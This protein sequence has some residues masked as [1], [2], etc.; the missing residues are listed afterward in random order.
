METDNSNQQPNSDQS[1]RE[2]KNFLDYDPNQKGTVLILIGIIFVI[3]IVGIGG[4]YLGKRTMNQS[5]IPISQELQTSIKVSSSSVSTATVPN[6][7]YV[8][9]QYDPNESIGGTKIYQ[10]KVLNFLDGI[11]DNNLLG[12][13][14]SPKY[15]FVIKD[16][17]TGNT[18]FQYYDKQSKKWITVEDQQQ[19]IQLQKIIQDASNSVGPT[20]AGTIQTCDVEDGRQIIVYQTIGD[21]QLVTPYFATS[22]SSREQPSFSTISNI[23]GGIFFSCDQPL[24]LTKTNQFYYKC[25]QGEATTGIDYYYKIDLISKTSTIVAKCNFE[26]GSPQPPTIRCE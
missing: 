5:P 24:E 11:L 22:N 10:A 9:R 3:L 16:T 12:T 6:K 17:K 21:K 23:K 13:S 14:C 26:S 25:G 19:K 15:Q 2:R 4:Y 20:S 18:D 8:K 1:K 7:L